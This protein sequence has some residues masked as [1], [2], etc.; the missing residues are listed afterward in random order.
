MNEFENIP[1][2]IELKTEAEQIICPNCKQEYDII[3]ICTHMDARGP[4]YSYCA[5]TKCKLAF[6]VGQ[7]KRMSTVIER[8]RIEFV[9]PTIEDN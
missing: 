6:L 2:L 9:E 4:S 3:E 8:K 1:E 5:C 7:L